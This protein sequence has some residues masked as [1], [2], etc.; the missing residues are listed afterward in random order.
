MWGD[1]ERESWTWDRGRYM[2]GKEKQIDGWIWEKEWQM[3]G[4]R[5]RQKQRGGCEETGGACEEVRRRHNGAEWVWIPYSDY[6]AE[7]IKLRSKRWPRQR[8]GRVFKLKIVYFNIIIIYDIQA[9][10]LTPSSNTSHN[11]ENTLA[12][13]GIKPVNNWQWTCDH[14]LPDELD[15]TQLQISKDTPDLITVHST[16]FCSSFADSSAHCEDL[17]YEKLWTYIQ[18]LMLFV[19][20]AA[21]LPLAWLFIKE[22]KNLSPA[23]VGPT[24]LELFRY[25]Y[26][27]RKYLR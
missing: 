25:R 18:V 20:L 10:G 23:K 11:T 14:K 12:L 19:G 8:W 2:W 17:I 7:V 16:C 9:F 13:V 22:H 21:N 3:D 1:G 24:Q 15:R 5:R 27:N 26:Q 4:R 6:K